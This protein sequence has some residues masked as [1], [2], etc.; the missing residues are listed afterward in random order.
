MFAIHQLRLDIVKIKA[1][2]LERLIP[3]K[4][5]H[6]VTSLL[7]STDNEKIIYEAS[8]ILIDVTHIANTYSSFLANPEVI[9]PLY[10]VLEKSKENAIIKH[11]LYIF[12]NL[13]SENEPIPQQVMTN[14][15]IAGFTL[16]LMKKDIP[17]NLRETVVWLFGE[18]FKTQNETYINEACELIPKLVAYTENRFNDNFFKEVI[19]TIKIITARDNKTINKI[20]IENDILD[21]LFE[22]IQETTETSLLIEIISILINLTEENTPFLKQLDQKSDFYNNLK[23]ILATYTTTIDTARS[24][25]KA[26]IKTIQLLITMIE[27]NGRV[28]EKIVRDN[29]IP[30]ILNF[31]YNY[32]IPQL[33]EE[34]IKFNQRAL[35]YGSC[36]I[37]TELIMYNTLDMFCQ[38]LSK[39]QTATPDNL[40]Y[41]LE[42]IKLLLEHAFGF[43][44]NRNI[45]KDEMVKLGMEGLIEKMC[46]DK[47]NEE[48]SK[49]S[50]EIFQTYFQKNN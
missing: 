10:E 13:M 2:N 15:N 27:T 45:I 39:E 47:N 38:V 23:N 6:K 22:F 40:R 5:F 42:G 8:W 20:V 26:I 17:L 25:K 12:A 14:T 43:L 11:L 30:K 36:R 46:L 35:E 49:L 19:N 9:K 24:E 4:M 34:I 18:L 31:A 33:N 41:S 1:S 21:K 44:Q 7:V 32:D 29:K 28:L 48:I 16:D 37:R 3:F 50:T